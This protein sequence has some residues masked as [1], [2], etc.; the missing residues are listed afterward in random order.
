MKNIDDD[1]EKRVENTLLSDIPCKYE[2]TLN[3]MLYC[4]FRII[5]YHV[6]CSYS[7]MNHLE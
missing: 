7:A 5:Q 1:I 4:M 6:L 2:C 3:I